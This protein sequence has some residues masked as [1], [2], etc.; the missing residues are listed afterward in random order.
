MAEENKKS[1]STIRYVEGLF[2]DSSHIDQPTGTV[3]YAKNAIINRA[4]G[5]LSNEEGNTLMASLPD[6][7]TVIGTIPLVD[8]EIV[9]FVDRSMACI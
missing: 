5:A 6:Y 1:P 3:R 4:Y 7:S 9:L 8:N 2:K